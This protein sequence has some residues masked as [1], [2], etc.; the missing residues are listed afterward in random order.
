MSK[1]FLGISKFDAA[2]QMVWDSKKVTNGHM[3]IAGPSGTGKTHTIKAITSALA[4]SA[5]NMVYIFDIQGDINPGDFITST[6]KFSET[7]EFGLNPLSIS[8]DKDFGGV[9]KRIRNFLYLISITSVKL[10]VNQE[11]VLQNLLADLYFAN[12]FYMENPATWDLSYDPRMT[13]AA[14]RFGK[15]QPTLQDLLR[16]SERKLRQTFLGADTKAMHC[17]EQHLKKVQSL[18]AK[19]KKSLKDDEV[20][21]EKSKTEC[22]EAY[23]KFVDNIETGREI[24][25]MIKYDSRDVLKSVVNRL[26]NLN[27]TG[28]FKNKLP[29]WDPTKAIRRYDI[30]ALSTEEQKIFINIALEEIFLNEKRKGITSDGPRTYVVV[31]EAK[32]FIDDSDNN[33]INTLLLQGRKYGISCILASQSFSHFN[34]DVIT[35][36]ATKIILGVDEMYQRQTA[37]KLRLDIK[38]LQYIKPQKTAL[39]QIKNTGDLSN[40]FEH[41]SFGG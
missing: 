30:S 40:K 35:N 20:D 2:K 6:V 12:G 22:I 15:R 36:S 37:D 10:G 34:E 31:D 27:A 19:Y 7:S 5:G 1:I 32:Q 16:F 41:I 39:I 18:E 11:S 29:V 9:R 14:K 26:N 17:L 24:D 25:D 28:I 38:A 4:R 3:L 33:Q 23:S 13:D 8:A 21:L